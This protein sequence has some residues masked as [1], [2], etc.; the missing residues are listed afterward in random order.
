MQIL[1]ADSFTS[2]FHEGVPAHGRGLKPDDL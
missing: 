1:S 2:E